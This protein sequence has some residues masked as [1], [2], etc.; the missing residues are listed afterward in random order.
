MI[1]DSVVIHKTRLLVGNNDEITDLEWVGPTEEPTHICIATNST[2]LRLFDLGSMNCVATLA[3]H[4]DAVLCTAAYAME[5][6]S[7][8][9]VSGTDI[10]ASPAA[11]SSV[12]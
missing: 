3:G 7:T 12:F 1:N 11:D 4:S 6:G 10:S 8:I 5:N 9:L 2:H